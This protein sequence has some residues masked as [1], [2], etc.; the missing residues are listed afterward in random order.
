M[1]GSPSNRICKAPRRF[2]RI[3]LVP[4]LGSCGRKHTGLCKEQESSQ[5][6][7]YLLAPYPRQPDPSLTML[8]IEWQLASRCVTGKDREFI[9]R[10]KRGTWRWRRKPALSL[11]L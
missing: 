11:L 5:F 6:N 1:H 10:R 3:Y 2:S 7:G 8:L 4:V 9:E